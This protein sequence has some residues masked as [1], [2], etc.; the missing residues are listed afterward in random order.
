[1]WAGSLASIRG[2]TWHWGVGHFATLEVRACQMSRYVS[3]GGRGGRGSAGV[4]IDWC[5]TA[6]W[7]QARLQKNILPLNMGLPLLQPQS[8]SRQINIKTEYKH[9][10]ISKCLSFFKHFGHSDFIRDL[11]HQDGR[12]WRGR[13]IRVKAKARPA[14]RF[15][16]LSMLSNTAMAT[17]HQF[18]EN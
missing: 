16:H 11:K 9:H 7:S 12:W 17:S 6:G 4:Y 1:M 14:W 13:H 15:T 18:S 3:A 10:K 2:K 5:I 8:R